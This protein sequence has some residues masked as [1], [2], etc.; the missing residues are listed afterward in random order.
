MAAEKDITRTAPA[1]RVEIAIIKMIDRTLATRRTGRASG[2]VRMTVDMTTSFLVELY[3]I[4]V[5]DQ[6]LS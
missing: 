1:I 5:K 2:Y 4:Y 3:P 6:R